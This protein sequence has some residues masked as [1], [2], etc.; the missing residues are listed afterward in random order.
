MSPVFFQVAPYTFR[1]NV[2][3]PYLPAFGRALLIT[4][5]VSIVAELVGIALGLIAALA[6]LSRWRLLRAIAIGYIDFFRGVPLLATLVWLYYGVTLLFGISFSAFSAG[7]A[8]LGITYGA[9]LAE[10]FRSGIQ[11][12]PKGQ[13]EASRTLGLSS[14]QI[15]MYVILP[16]AVRITLPPIGNTFVSMLKDSSLIAVLAVT[17]LMRQGM[18]VASDT[19]RAFEAYTFVAVIYYLVTVVVARGLG[20]V[21]R[22]YAI[23]R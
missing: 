21:E 13:T 5:Q 20:V 19:F 17:D 2:L 7:V 14:R 18:I 8:G 1:W 23:T 4:F 22:R 16:Q 9:Y 10:I 6:R 15:M 11:A 12:I 3:I